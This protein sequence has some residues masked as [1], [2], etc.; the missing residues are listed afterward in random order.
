VISHSLARIH[1]LLEGSPYQGY[2]YAYP[3]KTAYRPLTHPIALRDVWAKENKQ[4][5]F[6]YF[7]I[8]FCG[9]RCGFCNLFTQAKPKDTLPQLYLEALQRQA[10]QVSQGLEKRQFSRFAIGGGTPTYLDELQLEAC[11][12]LAEKTLGA[13]LQAI[14]G[15]VEVSP[16]TTTS[17]KLQLLRN[18]GIS[19]ISIGIQS[20]IESETRDSGRPQKLEEVYSALQQIRELK[21]PILNIDLIYGLPNQTLDTWLFSLREALRYRPE[22]L[23]LYPLYVRPLTGLGRSHKE[24]DDIRLKCYQEARELLLEEG[25]EQVS[26]RMFRFKKSWI[27][28]GPVYCCQ[29][30]GM[31]G[32]GCGAR[33]YTRNLHYSNEYAV[34]AKNV[35]EII[36]EFVSRS[37]DSFAFVDHG[38]YLN[39]NEQRRRHLLQSI[40]QAEGL[41]FTKYYQRFGTQLANDF[42]QLQELETLGLSCMDRDQLK[43]TSSGLERSDVIGPW[44]FSSEVIAR[45]KEYELR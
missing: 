19:R 9:M 39:E 11:L 31:V 37:D 27:E 25:Y 45:M 24:W 14:P 22:E 38:F 16:D 21:F 32:L 35:K 8:P 33:S 12:A 34:G 29:E 2:V 10:E 7:H 28:N 6:L 4:S 17:K 20:F 41:D 1:E 30:D 3:H 5:L 15:C 18:R 23:Y 44:L 42:P 26:M 13:N 43:L 36:R 40:L